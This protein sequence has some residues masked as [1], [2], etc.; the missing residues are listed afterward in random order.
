MTAECNYSSPI[1]GSDYYEGYARHDDISIRVPDGGYLGVKISPNCSEGVCFF[2]PAAINGSKDLL[3]VLPKSRE[4]HALK[5]CLL[6]SITFI[7]GMPKEKMV[8]CWIILCIMQM[9]RRR[10]IIELGLQ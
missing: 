4:A 2:Q 6:F 1:K 5:K 7:P 10:L 9:M 8:H 3:F